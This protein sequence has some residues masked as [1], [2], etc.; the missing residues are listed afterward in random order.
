[1]CPPV[2]FTSQHKFRFICRPQALLSPHNDT[3]QNNLQFN[4]KRPFRVTRNEGVWEFR[5]I[6][7]SILDLSS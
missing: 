5:L 3:E 7:P 1:M 4:E 6:F 2:F